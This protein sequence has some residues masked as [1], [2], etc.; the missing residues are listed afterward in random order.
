MTPPVQVRLAAGAL[1]DKRTPHRLSGTTRYVQLK[2][3]L[4]PFKDGR[5][6]IAVSSSAFTLLLVLV[7]ST[8]FVDMS[9]VLS[10]QQKNYRLYG[11]GVVGLLQIALIPLRGWRQSLK[12]ASNSVTLFLLWCT[13]SLAWTQHV[14]LTSKR[15]VLLGLVYCGTFVGVCDLSAKRSLSIVRILLVAALILNFGTAIAV[16]EIGTH[17]VDNL[18]L[19]RGIMGHKNIAGILCAVTVILFAFDCSRIPG[20]A[21]AGIVS[22]SLVFFYLAW[23]KTAWISLPVALASGAL[24]ALLGSSYPSSSEVWRKTASRAAFAL[25]TIALLSLILATLQQDMILS[26][27]NDTTALTARASIWRPMIQFYLDHPTLGSGYGA[28]WDNSANLIDAHPRNFGAWKNID[29][30]HN[31]YLDLLVQV[32]LPGLGIALYAAFVWPVE[33]LVGMVGR[34]PQRAALIIALLIFFLIE[35]FSESS[36]FADDVLGNAFLLLAL[37]YVQRFALRSSKR[38]KNGGTGEMVSA[39]QRRESRQRQQSRTKVG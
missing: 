10:E 34:H 31:G 17:I 21:R 9:G 11:Y 4:A 39:T 6:A 18:H 35:N 29:Q 32:G 25:Y 15:L 1:S 13:L 20:A 7:L 33:H 12:I 8:P 24:I 14:E 28:Y 36:I 5:A 37:A 19:W 27:T 2:L 30:G 3:Q 38:L 16:P 22:A 26:L 23:S